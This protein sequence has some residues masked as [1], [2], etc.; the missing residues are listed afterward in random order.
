MYKK[1]T[2]TNHLWIVIK[3]INF[4][5][6]DIRVSTVLEPQSTYRGRGEIGGVYLPSQLKSTPQLCSWWWI[7]WKGEGVHPHPCW[8]AFTVMMECKPE[9][10]HC[11]SVCTLWLEPWTHPR[12]KP[13]W[14]LDTHLVE[15]SG[16]TI[17]WSCGRILCNK[18]WHYTF[19][20]V[21]L[22]CKDALVV[23]RTEYII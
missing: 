19:L 13:L 20:I 22:Y 23:S 9:N 8:A 16:K 7:E 3:F 2:Q 17:A 6:G 18:D 12:W 5:V 1:G 15:Q 4:R 11:H 21:D 14:F 10:G